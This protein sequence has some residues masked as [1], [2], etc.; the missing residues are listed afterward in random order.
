[1]KLSIALLLLVP[2]LV[3]AYVNTDIRGRW[4]AQNQIWDRGV[5]YQLSF[6][7]TNYQTALTVDC[8]FN[9][10]AH[11]QATTGSYVNYNGNAIYIQEN[12]RNTSQDPFHFCAASLAP[13]VWTVYFDVYGRM[14]LTMPTPYQ[15]QLSLVRAYPQLN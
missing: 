2:Q 9:D 14:L 8:Y 6:L 13:S 4:V 12:Q 3:F 10:G 11:L 7:F 1:M 15:S 5:Q